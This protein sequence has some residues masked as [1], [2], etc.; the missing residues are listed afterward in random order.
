MM[1]YRLSLVLVPGHLI[2]LER[3]LTEGEGGITK[4]EH[5]WN[6]DRK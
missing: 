6:R 1:W 5:D 3:G 4:I 2:T